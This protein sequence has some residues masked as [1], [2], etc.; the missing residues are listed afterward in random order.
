[1][2]IIQEENCILNIDGKK[3]ETKSFIRKWTVDKQYVVVATYEDMVFIDINKDTEKQI[4]YVPNCVDEYSQFFSDNLVI[5]TMENSIRICDVEG[6]AIEIYLHESCIWKLKVKCFEKYILGILGPSH[7]PCKMFIYVRENMQQYIE[8]E[9][10]F[11]KKK[12]PC[13]IKHNIKKI[14]H[15]IEPDIILTDGYNGF[16][17]VNIIGNFLYYTD[18]KNNKINI[19]LPTK[20]KIARI[21]IPEWIKQKEKYLSE[22]LILKNKR[23]KYKCKL[24]NKNNVYK[25]RT[26]Y[27]NEKLQ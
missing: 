19:E 26:P 4:S 24:L 17:E 27:Y 10:F 12:Y 15:A 18:S 2:N 23:S 11:F 7:E 8:N 1:M 25:Y 20:P 9:K 5:L 21:P 22:L 6:N 14:N 3:H 13:E 16:N